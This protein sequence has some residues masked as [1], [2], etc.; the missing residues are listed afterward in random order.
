MKQRDL[1]FRQY[2]KLLRNFVAKEFLKRKGKRID[3][4]AK[5]E[6]RNLPVPRQTNSFD[7]GLFLLHYAELFLKVS[8]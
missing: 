1:K 3:L 5:M 2:S 8:D 7:C 6:M 4:S